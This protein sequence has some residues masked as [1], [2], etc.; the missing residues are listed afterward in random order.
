MQALDFTLPNNTY[1]IV[2][3]DLAGKQIG[4]AMQA[5]NFA[6]CNGIIW[7]EP[8][9]GAIASQGGS[10][11]VYAFG[12]FDLLRLGKTA[13]QV[14]Q[15]LLQGDPRP[16]QNQVAILDVQGNV[17]VHTGDRC[18]GEAGH[19]SGSGYSCQANLMRNQT[20]WHAMS[21]AFEQSQGELV[22]R[23]LAAL[24]AAENA[25]GDIRGAQSAAIKIVS[26]ERPSYPWEGYGYDFKVYDHPQ[27]LT[28]LRRL[29]DTQ[30][31]HN[32]ANKAHSMLYE[33]DLDDEKVAL[34]FEQFTAAVS[35]MPNMDSRVQHQCFYALSLS[36]CGR[37]AIALPLFKEVFALNPLWR[38]VIKRIG[39]FQP[40]GPYRDMIDQ[41]LAQ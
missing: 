29:V 14:L 33:K 25:G 10:D 23:M 21:A 9:V 1:S 30:K 3:I 5:H 38:E 26:S 8:G 2:A 28:E 22:D 13:P 41:I 37:I 19:A 39:V 40:E 6:A 35:S 27:P 17:A 36:R 16:Q 15:G 20:I 12:G 31:V 18:I 11:P 24:D 4:A 34:S 7:A 32:Q